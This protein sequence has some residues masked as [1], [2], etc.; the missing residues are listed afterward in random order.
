VR[1]PHPFRS[2]ALSPAARAP[3]NQLGQSAVGQGFFGQACAAAAIAPVEGG[4]VVQGRSGDPGIFAIGGRCA[5][6]DSCIDL[7][8]KCAP[9]E[10]LKSIGVKPEQIEFVIAT[11]WHQDHIR[12][13]PMLVKWASKAQFWCPSVFAHDDFLKFAS[14][15][16]EADI[17]TLGAPCSDLAAV[18]EL[19]DQ[20]DSRPRFAHQDTV[21]FSNAS[22][23]IQIFALSPVQS[24]I[25][26]F[27]QRV[28][29]LIPKFRQPRIRVGS[30]RSHFTSSGPLLRPGTPQ[31]R[32]SAEQS[33]CDSGGRDPCTGFASGSWDA[34]AFFRVRA[35]AAAGPSGKTTGAAR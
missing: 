2:L 21:I 3:G 17:S 8:G 31:E 25:Q 29:S 7:D 4:G 1:R 19:L 10:Y 35:Q 11:H 23:T 5:T 34:A 32:R 28:A 27:L 13:L 26:Q 22:S 20:R 6:V 14:A 15:Y 9:L 12:G 30:R 16:A 18:F 24:R 33:S